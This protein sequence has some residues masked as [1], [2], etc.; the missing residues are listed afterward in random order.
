[1]AFS[2]RNYDRAQEFLL[3]L[4]LYHAGKAT[5]LSYRLVRRRPIRTNG[6][7]GLPLRSPAFG[8][9]APAGTTTIKF[10]DL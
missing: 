9:Q 6:D 3:A 7:C 5:D 8:T 10:S 4:Q 2:S 1:M